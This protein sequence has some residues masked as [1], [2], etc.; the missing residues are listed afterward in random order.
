MAQKW[1]QKATVQVQLAAGAVALLVALLGFAANRVWPA[2]SE[3]TQRT[4]DSNRGST[5]LPSSSDGPV[6]ADKPVTLPAR[7]IVP[8]I[9]TAP[10]QTKRS[11][12]GSSRSRVGGPLVISQGQSGGQTAAT[13][14]NYNYGSS[15][16][17]ATSPLLP[18]SVALSY[19]D[20]CPG[21]DPSDPVLPEAE[22]LVVFWCKGPVLDEDGNLV[23]D[24][25]QLKIRPRIVNNSGQPL[26]IG[27]LA[28]SPLRLLMTAKDV[29]GRWA[30]PRLTKAAGDRPVLVAWGGQTFWGVP[31]NQAH[32]AYATP[33]SYYTGYATV[34]D[35]TVL[36]P[37][38]SYFKPRRP[39]PGGGGVREGD[40]VFQIPV[41]DDGSVLVA[42]LALVAFQADGSPR[43]V[44]IAPRK[45]WPNEVN[46]NEF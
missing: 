40:L 5:Q 20:T 3:S 25:V 43:L 23:V 24:H 6:A 12:D 21:I 33:T 35:G 22:V 46:A 13:I 29:A 9:S 15:T 45:A 42:G 11:I 16:T 39:R 14:N 38:Q 30:P 7:P 37:G 41:D 26:G 10:S 27:I 34:W 31:P 32:D 44:G 18:S 36:G 8:P 17:G 1:Y 4:Q 2:K 28:P 19:A